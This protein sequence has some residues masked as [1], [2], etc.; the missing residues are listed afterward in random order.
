MIILV[1][2]DYYFEELQIKGCWLLNFRDRKEY[3]EALDEHNK[4]RA[5][6]YGQIC[7][8]Y[9]LNRKKGSPRQISQVALNTKLDELGLDKE[10][11]YKAHGERID[12]IEA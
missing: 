10:T 6:T 4:L 3:Q 11:F 12:F 5:R 9:V 8:D 2:N 7:D 1:E